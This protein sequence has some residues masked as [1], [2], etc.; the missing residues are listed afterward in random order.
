MTIEELRAKAVEVSD[1]EG[2][3]SVWSQLF[4][5]TTLAAFEALDECQSGGGVQEHVLRFIKRAAEKSK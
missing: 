1:P 2:G 3:Y 5:R 4:A